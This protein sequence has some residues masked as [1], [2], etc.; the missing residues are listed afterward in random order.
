[1]PIRGLFQSTTGYFE[2]Q[3]Y[4]NGSDKF[5]VIFKYKQFVQNYSGLIYGAY[6][7]NAG[8]DVNCRY[9]VFSAGNSTKSRL[10]YYNFLDE[11]IS[12]PSYNVR[13]T[14]IDDAGTLFID[15]IKKKTNTQKTFTCTGTFRLF[16][17]GWTHIPERSA[18]V[19]I[20]HGKINDGATIWMVPL[21][22]NGNFEMVDL[23]S[24]NLATRVGTFTEF[25]EL[26]DG[27][28]WTPLNQTH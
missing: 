24:G 11:N 8:I 19:S 18:G 16:S 7:M 12:A 3:Y 25:Y 4:P 17:T 14:V 26:P 21:K 27:T 2:S 9:F 28:P 5:E 20:Y 22:R 13:H 23:V 15:G 10:V 1:M 6:D